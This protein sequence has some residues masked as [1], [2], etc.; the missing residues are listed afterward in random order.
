MDGIVPMWVRRRL[1]L[2]LPTR[3]Q[4]QFRSPFR[5][6]N[7]AQRKPTASETGVK[8]ITV[9]LH[10]E[11]SFT[12]GEANTIDDPWGSR[13][14]D[15]LVAIHT[16]KLCISSKVGIVCDR[17]LGREVQK[18]ISTSGAE[19]KTFAVVAILED[20]AQAVELLH[21]VMNSS[22]LNDGVMTDE[23]L[24]AT[25]V[26][27]HRTARLVVGV[28]ENVSLFEGFFRMDCI[29]GT[30]WEMIN[31]QMLGEGAAFGGLRHRFRSPFGR[32]SVPDIVQRQ[33]SPRQVADTRETSCPQSQRYL[34]GK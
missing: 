24:L 12:T 31:L 4:T 21:P 20:H 18:L 5:I 34:H 13:R 1:Q 9:S 17:I 32:R 6:L 3:V 25:H 10:R 22:S 28:I 16:R 2:A 30:I 14:I 11:C 29:A 7:H 8:D 15:A 33:D 26:Q 27:K 23:V 19:W